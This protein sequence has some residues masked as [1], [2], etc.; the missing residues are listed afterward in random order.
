LEQRFDHDFWFAA[1]HNLR[2]DD[3]VI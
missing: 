3:I 2:V 1:I